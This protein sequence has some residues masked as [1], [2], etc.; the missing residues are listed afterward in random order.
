MQLTS[1]LTSQLMPSATPYAEPYNVHYA[2]PFA[3]PH[4]VGP[5]Q[6]K[7]DLSVSQQ[8][9]VRVTTIM[10]RLRAPEQSDTRAADTPAEPAGPQAAADPS[11]PPS[12]A[13]PPPPEGGA[14]ETGLTLSE[15]EAVAPPSPA[16]EEASS[17]CNGEA[18]TALH[19]GAEA[20]GEQG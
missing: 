20:G 18:S 16:P 3:S 12:P 19:D 6:R 8:K 15:A 17:R 2:A 5:K 1:H 10:K 4:A 13:P 14:T 11:H 7:S 9:A